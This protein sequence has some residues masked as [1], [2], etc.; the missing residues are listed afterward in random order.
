M[1][2]DAVRARHRGLKPNGD[3]ARPAPGTDEREGD[4][5]A[6]TEW[7]LLVAQAYAGSD[8]VRATT[9]ETAKDKEAV[10]TP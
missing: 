5:R 9:I 2:K 3:I 4:L 8:V 7:L 6:E 10:P 1:L